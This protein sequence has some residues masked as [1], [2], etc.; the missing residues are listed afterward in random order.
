VN[1]S[2]GGYSRQPRDDR[3][4]T[5]HAGSWSRSRD[6]SEPRRVLTLTL[7][8]LTIA[9]SVGGCVLRPRQTADERA[10]VAAA[11]QPFETPLAARELPDLPPV[12]E[13]RDVL[14]RAFLVN[15]DLESAYFEWKAAL[16]RVDQAATW[17]NTNVALT[18]SYMFS[19]ENVKAWD[20]T[21][22]GV[23]FDP[24][25]NLSLPI[26]ARAGGKVA[27]DAAQEAGEKFRAVKFDLQRKVLSAYLEL[28]LTEELIRIQQDNRTLLK[29]VTDSAADRAEAGGPMQD[30]FKATIESQTAENDLATLEAKARS[31]RSMLNGMLAREA[32]APL[33]LPARLPSPRPVAADDARLIA[34][35]VAQN[36]ELAE[37]ARQVAGRTDAIEVARLAYLPDFSPSASITGNVSQ[38]IGTMLML[39]TKTPA[40]RAAIDEGQSMARSSEA[41]LR[42]TRHDRAGSFVATLYLMRNAERQTQLY[43]RYIVP[44]AQQL[45]SSSRSAYAAGTI[46]FADLIDSERM[47]L[48]VRRMVAEA[49][50]DREQRLADLEALAG[51]DVETLGSASASPRRDSAQTPEQQ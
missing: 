25:M 13:W 8:T 31:M 41:M 29:L 19:S 17:P 51:V 16:A 32:N 2:G 14:S 49:Q 37:L 21:T 5:L 9:L 28:A 39:P 40:I 46:G 35:G 44:A 47:L 10:K 11:S 33:I 7:V 4:I 12:V 30:F 50:I 27:L 24:S 45:V 18:F 36:P 6:Y 1:D 48:M 43:Q 15:G 20:R 42:Q 22:L 3:T 38:T 34:A 23:G 26:K